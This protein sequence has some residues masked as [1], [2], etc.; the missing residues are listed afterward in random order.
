MNFQTLAREESGETSAVLRQR[1]MACRKLQSGRYKSC[2]KLNARM[3]ARD[4][5]GFSQPDEEG[6]K[7]LE[8]AMRELRLSARAYF[9][10]LKIARTIA[11]LEEEQEVH[12][13][14]LAEAIQYRSLDRQWWV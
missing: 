11:D 8:M 6:R 1:I 13:R 9:K 2:T 10:I 14:H 3:R 4:I 5:R 12:S 7:L